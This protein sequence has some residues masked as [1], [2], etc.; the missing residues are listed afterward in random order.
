[1]NK[2]KLCLIREANQTGSHIV[3][4]FFVASQIGKRGKEEGYM[5]TTDPSQN[6]SENTGATHIKQDNIFCSQCEKRLSFLENTIAAEYTNKINDPKYADNFE[7]INVKGR[8]FIK[9]KRLNSV[10]FLLFVY[11]ILFRA[12]VSRTGLYSNFKIDDDLNEILR[13]NLDAL[14]PE[15]IDHEIVEKRKDWIE[16]LSSAQDLVDVV[17]IV[18]IK[19]NGNI[20]HGAN[21][22]SYLPTAEGP[23]QMAANDH[24]IYVAKHREM[25]NQLLDDYFKLGLI[26]LRHKLF[27]ITKPRIVVIPENLWIKSQLFVMETVLEVRS[28]VAKKSC[29]LYFI[30]NFKRLPSKQE[31]KSCVA[32]RMSQFLGP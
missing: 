30:K 31:L 29:Y 26:N 9:L 16:G 19:P 7:I 23:F 4:A 2:C 12:H 5:M 8:S 13:K 32:H 14:L 3:S 20:D 15:I 10:A 17:D 24:I 1:M 6:Y 27:K 18:I 22:S 21:M 28:L 25:P 11:S